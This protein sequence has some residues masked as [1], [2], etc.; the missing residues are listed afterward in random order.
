MVQRDVAPAAAQIPP[1][2]RACLARR[3][4]RRQAGSCRQAPLAVYVWRW[5]KLESIGRPYLPGDGVPEGGRSPT[6]V[7]P[8]PAARFPQ[9]G[10]HVWRSERLGAA[11]DSS[12][13]EGSAACL[14][15]ISPTARRGCT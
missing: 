10:Q 5:A 11:S 14:A 4:D 1:D 9:A 8:S 2:D 12:S 3:T 6:E 7:S 15:D 13:S